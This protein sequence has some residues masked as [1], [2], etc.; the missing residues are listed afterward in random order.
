MNQ[1]QL[2]TDKNSGNLRDPNQWG[3]EHEN[4]RY[5]VDLLEK[6][7]TVAI[8]TRQLLDHAP[9]LDPLPRILDWPTEWD[10]VE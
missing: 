7:V 8:K 4:P 1:Y 9:S 3:V 10:T 2:K 6:L 5:V